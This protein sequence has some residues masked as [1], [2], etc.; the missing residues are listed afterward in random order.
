MDN[1]ISNY[2]SL[3]ICGGPC[4][5]HCSGTLFSSE[6][7]LCIQLWKKLFVYYEY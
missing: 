2:F 5:Q 1:T 4:H 3:F 7:S 6:N